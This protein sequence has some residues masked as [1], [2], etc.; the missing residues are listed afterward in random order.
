M[1]FMDE[2][3]QFGRKARGNHYLHVLEVKNGSSHHGAVETTPT[4]N[5]EVA[6]LIPGLAQRVKDPVLPRAVV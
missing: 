2:G 1:Q 3:K 5:D 6:G 4:R